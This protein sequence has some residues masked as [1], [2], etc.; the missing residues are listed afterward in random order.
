MKRYFPLLI[1]FLFIAISALIVYSYPKKTSQTQ[2]EKPSTE[3]QT[4]PSPA[5]ETKK[6]ISVPIS[7][8]KSRVT[9]KP[10]GIY[11][12]PA[13]SPVQ[14]EKFTGYHTGTDFEITTDELNKE[15]PIYAIC[16]GKIRQKQYV[17]GYGGVIIQDCV[18]ENQTGTVLYGHINIAAIST[19]IG[20][21]VT[22]GS[23]IAILANANSEYSG[24]ERKHLH[25]GIHKG[26]A[27]E[28]RG[29]VGSLPE[30]SSWLDIAKYF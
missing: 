15:M 8:A 7:D 4:E 5:P 23:Q 26:T 14:P 28:Y 16:D 6:A 21:Q 19:Q 30:L 12:T 27:I 17:S 25:L 2:P 24:G 22:S 20:Q 1:V 29:Y 3:S 11:I 18:I 9:K 13:T 10:F